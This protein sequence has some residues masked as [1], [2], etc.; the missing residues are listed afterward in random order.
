MIVH[1]HQHFC[2]KIEENIFSH[3]RACTLMVRIEYLIFFNLIFNI[4]RKSNSINYSLLTWKSLIIH[5]ML[6]F[7]LWVCSSDNPTSSPWNLFSPN[8]R[9]TRIRL[10][11]YLVFRLI[12]SFRTFWMKVPL[13]YPL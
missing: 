10:F 3:S 1:I 13:S 5:P 12:L 4:L 11:F 9:K 2:L 7:L 8:L 6:L